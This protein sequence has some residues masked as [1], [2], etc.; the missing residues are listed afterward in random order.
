MI[1]IHNFKAPWLVPILAL[2]GIATA[3][4]DKIELVGESALSGTVSAI[5]E[6]GG[7]RLD[8]PVAVGPL[9]LK[10]GTVRRVVFSEDTGA[11][12][13][14]GTRLKL[15]DG[16]VIP[17][18][19]RSLDD[20]TL[21]ATTSFAGD[22]RIPRTALSALELGIHTEKAIYDGTTGIDGWVVDRWKYKDGQFTCGPGGKLS[23]AFDLPDQFI[24]RF[25][26]TWKGT[27]NL[28]VS[29]ADP[30]T[31]EANPL[32]RYY[33]QFG[34]AGI[35]VRRQS[36]NGRAPF[37]LTQLNRQPDSFTRSQTNVEIRVDRSRQE[38]KMWLY[39]DG[40]LEA[41]FPDVVKAPPKAGGISFSVTAGGDSEHQISN[42]RILS[43]DAEGDRHRTEER[44]DIKTDALIDSEGDR[45]SGQL[46]A[47]RPA[48]DGTSV[49]SFK[50]PLLENVM[51]IPAKKV[52]TVFFQTQEDAP[53]P[54]P[55][56]YILKLQGGGNLKVETCSFSGDHVDARHALLGQLSVKRSAVV[57]I[58][59][60]TVIHPAPE[61]E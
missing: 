1:G 40:V 5:T 47:I 11:P 6:G 17:C 42:L 4:A 22:L 32:D 2:A 45:Y 37:T 55:S 43:W 48:A 44:G 21:V 57:S 3:S 14:G 38:T 10:P 20:S 24:L 29:F 53:P 41:R 13:P 26:F 8:S 18:E 35:E 51:S 61:K 28:K 16:D 27:P 46:Q 23:R 34:N 56:P 36:S 54:P 60:S 39:L 49:F 50:S 12:P 31:D 19:L 9:L 58:D 33:L 25:R 59:Q 15:A 7:V 52:S 30:L